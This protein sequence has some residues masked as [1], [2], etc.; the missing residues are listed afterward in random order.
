MERSKKK[1]N[2]PSWKN[3]GSTFRLRKNNGVRIIKP[4]Q[5][6]QADPADI[7]EGIRDVIIC[8]DGAQDTKQI[9]DAKSPKFILNH[10]GGGW[11]DVLNSEE[12]SM[13]EEALKKEDAEALK[14]QLEKE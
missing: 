1:S 11:Y 4:N 12:N 9:N 8:L 7:P 2:F 6:F 3:T 14:E 10:R 13:N 5:I